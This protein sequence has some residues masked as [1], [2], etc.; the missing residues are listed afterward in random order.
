[1]NCKHVTKLGSNHREIPKLVKMPLKTLTKW[2]L[3][4]GAEVKEGDIGKV[5]LK[6]GKTFS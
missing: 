2:V 5:T 3:S 4:N 1:M 6:G